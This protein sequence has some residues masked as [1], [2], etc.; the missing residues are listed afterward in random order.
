MSATRRTFPSCTFL[1]QW[2]F[3]VDAQ[4]YLAALFPPCLKPSTHHHAQLNCFW[5]AVHC[6]LLSFMSEAAESNSVDDSDIWA[7]LARKQLDE[8]ALVAET[9]KQLVNDVMTNLRLL[10]GSL[11]DDAWMYDE[12]GPRIIQK[13]SM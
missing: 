11:D 8:E 4:A 9:G 5:R 12:N 2:P 13:T 10:V 7:N 6:A 1:D 3:L